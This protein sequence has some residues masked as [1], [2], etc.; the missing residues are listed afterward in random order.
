MTSLPKTS[1]QREEKQRKGF[2]DSQDFVN[3]TSNHRM[4]IFSSFHLSPPLLTPVSR[5]SHLPTL[6]I[7]NAFSFMLREK[8]SHSTPASLLLHSHFHFH[9]QLR[10]QYPIATYMHIEPCI[11]MYTYM[12]IYSPY[13]CHFDPSYPLLSPS[14]PPP[15]NLIVFTS[16]SYILSPSFRCFAP[17]S[18]R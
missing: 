18:L 7:S 8:H 9:F 5:V 15:Y 12:T 16:P 3:Q 11:Y 6:N 4:S 14:I 10:I 13:E 1:D 17:Y 2:I